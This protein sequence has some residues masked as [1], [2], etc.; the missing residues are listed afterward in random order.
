M[1][2]NLVCIIRCLSTTKFDQMMTLGWSWPILG[3]SQIWSLMLLYGEKGKTMDFSATIVVYDLK[4]A[5][6]DL[7]DKKFLL[8]SKLCPLGAVCHL[9]WGYIHVLNHEKKKNCIKS[10]FKVVRPFCW[11]QHFSPEGCLSLP[12]GCIHVLNHET[13]CIK[14]DFKDIFYLNLQ[15]MNELTRHFCWHQNLVPVGCLPLPRGYIH[16]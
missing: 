2:W 10:D 13:N 16:V 11:H 12:R 6:D 9:P 7:S 3:Q 5:T 15:Q 1:T 8:T 4:L 14:S